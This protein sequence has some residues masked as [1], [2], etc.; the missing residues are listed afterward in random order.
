MK[1]FLYLLCC[2]LVVGMA[3][4]A[5][6]ENYR[7]QATA[8]RVQKLQQEIA[9]EREAISVLKA[10]WAYLNRPERLREL[11]D[12]NFET[13]G[14]I[15]LSSQHFGDTNLV[16]FPPRPTNLEIVNEPIAVQN[17]EGVE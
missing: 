9:S 16:A 8:K 11:A 2:A 15:P 14:L 6:T 4:W 5:Y 12:L 13:L 17:S 1:N 3:Y 10:E 7:T